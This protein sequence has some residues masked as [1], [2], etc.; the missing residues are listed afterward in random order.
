[1]GG[2]SSLRWRT[3]DFSGATGSSFSEATGGRS[4]ELLGGR[5][6]E[7]QEGYSGGGSRNTMDLGLP[8]D[9]RSGGRMVARCEVG[10]C[11]GRV[12]INMSEG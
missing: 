8:C 3:E 2:K 11:S 7:G 12:S 10:A 1:M 4:R 9:V 6:Q 5:R